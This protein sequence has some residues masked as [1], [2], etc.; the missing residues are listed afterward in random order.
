M[1]M[2][3]QE[4]LLASFA[5]LAGYARWAIRSA[6]PLQ[7]RGCTNGAST[8]AGETWNTPIRLARSTAAS[9]TRHSIRHPVTGCIGSGS[10]Q[11]LLTRSD[12]VALEARV[13]DAQVVG[14]VNNR[15][16]WNL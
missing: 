2:R 4:L 11:A 12:A 10:L 9:N 7:A 3:Q 15:S 1:P 16:E 8:S 13:D 6:S 5:R 14:R